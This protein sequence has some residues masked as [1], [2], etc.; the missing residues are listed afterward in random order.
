MVVRTTSA[1]GSV[2]AQ[3]VVIAVL[4]A[5]GS[6]FAEERA[7]PQTLRVA[8]R[9][10]EPFVYV[11]GEQPK[12]FSIDVVEAIA[13]ELGMRA[14]YEVRGTIDDLLDAARDSAADAAIGAITITA[15]REAEL[16][17]SHPF[18]RSGLRLAVPS[19]TAPTW[20]STLRRFAAPDFLLMLATI[21]GVTLL[22]AH[23]LWAIERRVN[24]DCF[25]R[26]YVAGVGEALWW[27]VA[28]IITGGCENKAPVSL[29]GRLVAVAW[30]LGSIVLVASFTATLASQMTSEA[31]SGIISGPDALPGR[32]V[33]TV[34]GTTSE[35]DLRAMQARV[36]SC[37]SL[38]AAID[39]AIEG[40]ADAV[41]FDA[42]VLAHRL[43]LSPDKPIRLVGPMFEHCDYGIAMPCGSVLRK[44]I[45]Q[46]L[47]KLSESNELSKL[48]SKWFGEPN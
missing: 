38:D 5:T 24:P 46:A 3:A 36:L 1:T 43:S 40:K 28:T 29:A 18:Y 45:N 22:A 32:T 27:S 39:A 11:E 47:L 16:D 34:K 4:V 15:E 7:E 33:A 42:P 9:H 48:N 19:R 6:A 23:L 10:I 31:V 14:A 26:A 25:P 17:F 2:L 13:R 8:I 30:M 35:D 37:V 41:V 21:G 20:L 12:G 44:Q